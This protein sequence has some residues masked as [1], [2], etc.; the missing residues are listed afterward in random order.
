MDGKCPGC[1]EVIPVISH[2]QTVVLCVG[3][4]TVLCQPAGGKARRSKG[5]SF[6]RKQ[7]PESR[8]SGEPSPKTQ[9]E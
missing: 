5:C 8:Y 6:G 3:C 1:C 4:S 7:H 2:V 9:F